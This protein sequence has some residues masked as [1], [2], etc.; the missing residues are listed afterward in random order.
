MNNRW[1]HPSL[2]LAIFMLLN[3]FCGK[4]QISINLNL[5]ESFVNEIY[6]DCPQ[7][8]DQ[9]QVDKAAEI[10]SRILI[11]EVN[12]GEYPECQLLSGVSPKNKCNPNLSYS[13][14]GFD[15]LSF[16]PLKY[17]L[18]FYPEGSVYY[19]VDGLNYIIEIQSRQ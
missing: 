2:T 8:Q 1:L 15:P 10:L 16:N 11:H 5:A 18:S 13:L 4:A 12:L 9:Y 7:Y 17:H 3:V 14:E 19:R 6:L